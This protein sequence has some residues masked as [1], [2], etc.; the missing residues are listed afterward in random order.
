APIPIGIKAIPIDF[1]PIPTGIR[2]VQTRFLREE[3]TKYR[4]NMGIE[5]NAG[6][7]IR[8]ETALQGKEV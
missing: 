7:K 6:Q 4:E 1:A 3:T 8:Q 5:A 2:A